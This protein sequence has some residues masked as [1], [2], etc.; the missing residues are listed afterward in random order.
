MIIKN[1]YLLKTF[2]YEGTGFILTSSDSS[3][4]YIPNTVYVEKDDS[5]S[6]CPTD[7]EARIRAKE[8]GLNY[9]NDI[10]EIEKDLYV[11]TLENRIRIEQYISDK[12]IEVD[13]DFSELLARLQE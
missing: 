9:I 10:N 2:K 8:F 13:F 5:M 4:L 12:D 6:L 3:E 11:D 1:S 7:E